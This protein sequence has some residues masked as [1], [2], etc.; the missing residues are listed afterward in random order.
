MCGEGGLVSVETKQLRRFLVRIDSHS[1]NWT[2]ALSLLISLNLPQI[3]T[4]YQKVN[5][6]FLFLGCRTVKLHVVKTES[7][8]SVT[9]VLISPQTKDIQ[10]TV[11]FHGIY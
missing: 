7:H 3:V 1:M 9:A 6:S 11:P 10:R 2:L 4:F 5:A 8:P